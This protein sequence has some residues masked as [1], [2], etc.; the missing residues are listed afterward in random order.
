MKKSTKKLGKSFF[1]KRNL[2][3][4]QINSLKEI[5]GGEDII[6]QDLNEY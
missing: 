4:C 2:I 5:K 3:E 1:E 6:I